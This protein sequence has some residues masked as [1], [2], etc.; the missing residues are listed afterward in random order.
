MNPTV[1]QEYQAG[2]ESG[3]AV[4]FEQGRRSVPT[5]KTIKEKLRVCDEERLKLLLQLKE[6][7]QQI[8]DLLR[9]EDE[10]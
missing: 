2:F 7:Q 5:N 4:G 8:R 9:L 10:S 6:A 1:G 3:Y